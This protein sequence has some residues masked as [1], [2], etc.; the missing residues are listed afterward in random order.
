MP[1]TAIIDVKSEPPKAAA[2][3]ASVAYRSAAINVAPQKAIVMALDRVLL[4][5]RRTIAATEA[6][7]FDEAF[8]NISHSAQ[9]LRGL[10]QHL[11]VKK[12][13][14][15]A[16]QLRNLYNSQAMA[17]YF[18]IGKPDAVRRFTKLAEGLGEL[19]DAWA[20]VAKLPLRA[21]PT[22]EQTISLP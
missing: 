21:M 18:A 19:R 15:F 5:L 17:M 8:N 6:K 10:A 12:G 20:V 22:T 1:Q 3:A 14:E 7:R 4:N 13:G 2:I 9:I 11:D 16:E